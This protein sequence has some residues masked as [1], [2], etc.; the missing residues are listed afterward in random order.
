MA[1]AMIASGFN[2]APIIEQVNNWV[3]TGLGHDAAGNDNSHKYVNVGLAAP[4][5]VPTV[6]AAYVL[7]GITDP[8]GMEKVSQLAL[9][10]TPP[11]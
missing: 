5:G 2:T 7:A 6:G 4:T 10:Y 8:V 11:S 1:N 9:T 3:L